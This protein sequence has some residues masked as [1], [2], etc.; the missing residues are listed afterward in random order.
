MQLGNNKIVNLSD[1][2]DPQDAVNR[3]FLKFSNLNDLT[4]TPS[5]T[6]AASQFLAFTGTDTNM[7]NVT[8][9]GDLSAGAIASNSL[10]ITV[11]NG[12][13]TN[14]KVNA[15]AAIAQSKLAMKAAD[16]FVE[17]TGWTGAKTQADLGLAKFSAN[18]FENSDGYIR[19]KDNGIVLA[20]LQ[21]IAS[22]TLLGNNSGTVGAVAA[23]TFATVVDAGN[24]IKKGQYN[25]TGFLR[26]TN[27][28]S[29]VNDS[30]YS[31][32]DMIAGY[33]GSTANNTLVQRDSSGNFGAN[34]VTVERLNVGNGV[35]SNSAIV[36]TVAGTGGTIQ[37][38]GYNN[39]GGIII[40]GGSNAP[41]RTTKY[42]NDSHSFRNAAD[43]AA[44]PIIASSVQATALTTGGNTTAGTITGRWTLTG[45]SPNESRLQATYSADLAEYYEGDKDYEVGT[46]LVFGGDKEVTLSNKQG[47][48]RVAGVV[49]NTA[50]FVMYDACP[51]FKNLIALQGRVPC[52]VVGKIKKGDM[53][54]TS[55]IPGVAVATEVA[56]AGTIV[57]KALENYDSDHIG[58]IEVAVGRN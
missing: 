22:G 37:Y 57:G 19:I 14:A 58:T 3:R 4:V 24:S 25:N 27:S 23:I 48:T 11:V 41:D 7:V 52:K 35:A 50:A 56:Q 36:R 28:S 31:V 39:S 53:L 47:D 9:S 46:V 10:P 43:S 40:G 49:S 29:N 8:M 45:T 32:V 30:D 20:E 21:Q 2:T 38:F 42:L 54:V 44:A 5:G 12:A 1:P 16:T 26:R 13:I 33:S 55:R 51:G 18:N 15:S 34:I 17:S 6:A